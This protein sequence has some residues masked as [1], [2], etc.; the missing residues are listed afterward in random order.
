MKYLVDFESYYDK[1]ISVKTMG[2]PN[3]VAETDAYLVSV[4]CDDFQFCGPIGDLV[5]TLGTDFITD[6]ANEFWAANSNFD[7]AWWEK[8]YPKTHKPWK[9]VLDLAAFSQLPRSLDEVARVALGV[10][11]DKAVRSDMKG[12]VFEDLPDE[13]QQRVSDYCLQDAVVGHRLLK[14]LPAMSSS[15][16]QAAAHTRLVNRRGVHV[17]L[18]CVQKDLVRLEW[19]KAEAIARLPWVEDD[20]K[21]LSYEAFADTVMNCG[22]KPPVSLDKRNEECQRWMADHPKLAPWIE[23][24]RL[25]RGA[26]AKLKKLKS[27]EEF[28]RDGVMPLSLLYCGARHT[29]RWSCTGFNV[30]NLDRAPAFADVLSQ[31]EDQDEDDAPELGISMRHYLVPPPGKVFGILDYSQIEPRALNWI[32]GNEDILSAIRAGYGIYEAYALTKMGWKGQPGTMK[33]THAQLY[34][35]TKILVLA[36]GYGMGPGTFQANAKNG[37]VNLSEDQAAK[38]VLEFRQSNPLIV[39]K[40]AEFDQLIRSVV[41]SGDRD[42]GLEI[43]MPTGDLLQ[44]FDVKMVRNGRGYESFTIRG[45][46]GGQSRQPRLWGGTLTE[47]VTQRVARDILAE[48]ILRLENAGFPVIFHAHDEVIL[49]LDTATARQDLEEAKQLM[50]R[51]PDWCPGLPLGVDGDLS[52]HYT[53]L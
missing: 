39:A 4:V 47:N 53:K 1:D 44:Q 3:Y 16:E 41:L 45:D 22:V 29:R 7:Q 46:F 8:Y 35:F 36:L 49:S 6:P 48:A 18:P 21:P 25:L 12:V 9:C 42:K 19:V 43:Q 34:H 32:V 2:I 11:L 37:G 23:S 33:K 30:Q 5:S 17:D 13:A 10:K 31:L 52:P 40:W 24:M 20:R 26:N 50:L 28:E 38:Y 15:E 51:S 14:T 27:L